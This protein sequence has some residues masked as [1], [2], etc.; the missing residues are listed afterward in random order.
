[1]PHPA[2]TRRLGNAPV[3]AAAVL[4]LTLA[5]CGGHAARTLDARDALDAGD[6]KRALALINEE[7]GVT[8]AADLPK[9][10]S[11]DQAILLLDRAM[12]LQQL[13]E[14]KFSARDLGVADKQVEVLD[15]SR[16]AGAEIGR[17][18]FSDSSGAYKAPAYEKLMINTMNMVNYLVRSD[19][20]GARVE[21][22]RLAVM[23]RF[24]GETENPGAS[25]LAPG[26][27]LAGFTFEKSGRDEEALRY[28]DEA[29]K[30]GSYRTLTEP[31]RR[32][33]KTARYRSPRIR[34]ILGD[35]DP[36][37]APKAEPRA[38]KKKAKPTKPAKAAARPAAAAVP[39][40]D[41]V[42]LESGSA[43]A[44]K[45]D[46]VPAAAQDKAGSGALEGAQARKPSAAKKTDKSPTAS[47]QAGETDTS[48]V[49]KDAVKGASTASPKREREGYGELM[50]V[51]SFGRVPAKFAKRIPIGLALTYASGAISPHDRSQANAFAMQGLVTWVNYP[52]L[53]KGRGSYSV[54][55]FYLDGQGQFLE[56]ILAVDREARQ[57]WEQARGA[58][59]GSA[60]T[61]LVTR[62]VA[63]EA[64][65]R[66][67]GGGALG[68][69]LSL[70]TQ[71]TLTAADTPDTRSWATLPARIAFG[72]AWVKAGRHHIRLGARSIEKRGYIDVPAGSFSIVNLTVLH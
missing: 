37:R 67:S 2:W 71:A 30:Y 19:L 18:L 17:Y 52:E 57:A 29:L 27:Y 1:M 45:P 62:I 24:L 9:D 11:G 36:L 47:R 23:Q 55:T 32:L 25:L 5:S 60:I 66:G 69:L 33:A 35:A 39:T 38:K 64:V 7:L 43:A 31:I 20:S 15:L 72:R 68:L 14:Y 41:K 65:R 4:S 10:L 34:R 58:V 59:V 3:G 21:A 40:S 42:A 16:G 26:S 56:G 6:P 28:Y 12:V 44:R 50:V 63:G 70:G 13:E 53:G 61:R 48:A 8:R 51:V 22:R 54:P 49:A 46:G